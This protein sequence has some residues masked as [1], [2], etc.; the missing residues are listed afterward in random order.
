[1]GQSARVTSID[2]IKDFREALCSFCASVNDGLTATQ[3]D[4]RRT[5]DWLLYEQPAY[6]ER[7]LKERE[8]RVA[9]AQADWHRIKMMKA[10]GYQVDDIEPKEALDAAKAA[11]KEAEEKIEKVRRWGRTVMRAVQEYEGRARQLAEI[12]R[13]SCRERVYVLV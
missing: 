13:A 4:S 7:E 1:M 2:S 12:G 11:V 5:L 6:W 10:Q 3:M 9:Q 8:Q